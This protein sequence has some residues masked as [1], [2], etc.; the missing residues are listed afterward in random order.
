MRGS[1]S[2]RPLL[3][4]PAVELVLVN[5]GRC[6]LHPSV[7]VI[8]SLGLSFLF[9]AGDQYFGSFPQHPIM[10]QVSLLSAP[11]LAM[12]FLAGWTQ[13]MPGSAMLLGVA[14][15]C[16][17]LIGYGAMTLSPLE[18]AHY[19]AQTIAGFVTSESAVIAGGA[20]TGPLFG[21]LGYRWRTQR[22]WG[23]ALGTASTFCLEPLARAV[24]LMHE[25]FARVG[26]RAITATAVLAGEGAVGLILATSIA[27]LFVQ[28]ARSE[29]QG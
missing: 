19:S 23:G 16:A 20:L 24:V 12:A 1:A 11:W 21:W 6:W 2:S 3:R 18:N 9:G 28:G 15:T 4:L 14:C 25:P 7:A 5:S 13:L 17:A 22:A 26:G 27:I 10:T 8:I 29:M